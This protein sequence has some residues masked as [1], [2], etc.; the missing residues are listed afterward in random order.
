[1]PRC[2]SLW[3]PSGCRRRSPA[4]SA[5]TVQRAFGGIDPIGRPVASSVRN[6]SP[7]PPRARL[8]TPATIPTRS[9][10]S[11][12]G[13]SGWGRAQAAA[14]RRTLAPFQLRLRRDRMLW[15]TPNAEAVVS[16]RSTEQLGTGLARARC[17]ERRIEL[18][19]GEVDV[20]IR[21][22]AGDESGLEGRGSEV[23]AALERRA[24]PA[25]EQRRVRALRLGEVAD[26]PPGEEGAPHGAGVA[27]RDPDPVAA[28]GGPYTRDQPGGSPPERLVKAGPLGL[29]RK[30]VV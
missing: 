12:P 19:D 10:G 20:R 30:S 24:V 14:S 7:S 22:R 6:N 3:E 28:R 17:R 1:M 29:D 11:A 9:S 16:L 18:R 15:A 8:A 21:V 2:G 13:A 26:R 5:T 4:L 27:R 23:H 25:G